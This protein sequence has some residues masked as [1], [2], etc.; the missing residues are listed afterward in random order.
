MTE[1]TND[2][3]R[4][5]RLL[6]WA[7]ATGLILLPL[8]AV[9]A[10]DASAWELDDL[11]FAL[12]MIAAVGI[13]FEMALR[14]PDGWTGLAGTAAA[15]ATAFLL[16]WGNLAVGFAGSEDNRINLIFFAAPLV[17]L[18]GSAIARFRAAGVAIALT[19]AAASQIATGVLAL[20]GGHFTIPLTVSF[21]GF[22]LG[23]ALL[24][25][26]SAGLARAIG[27]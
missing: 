24:F 8:L 23:S 9:K 27:T 18:V 11:P 20:F 25:R 26:R 3:A 17:A 15:S 5:I 2:N 6:A 4:R 22:W 21:T 10:L 12:T 16:V 1:G 14:I 7:S 13:T 19:A